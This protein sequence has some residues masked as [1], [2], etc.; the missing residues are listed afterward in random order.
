MKIEISRHIFEKYSNYK[1][2]ENPS[3]ERHVVPCRQTDGR[4][5]KYDKVNRRFLQFLKWRLRTI[6]TFRSIEENT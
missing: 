6:T 5:D 4:T 2:H 3:S 1:F